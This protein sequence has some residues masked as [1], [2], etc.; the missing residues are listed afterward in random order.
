MSVNQLKIGSPQNNRW[1]KCPTTVT[2]GMPVLIG[3]LAAVALD[4]YD[5][6]TGGTT[7]QLDGTYSLTV[8]GQSSQSP[9]SGLAINPGDELFASGTFDATTNVTTALTI[10]KTRGNTPFGNYEGAGIASGVTDTAAPVRLKMGGS[11]PY[12][13]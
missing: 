4:A 12:A 11:G 2:S 10:D 6:S 5:S 3:T 1:Y 7:F 13:P 8:I 9:V